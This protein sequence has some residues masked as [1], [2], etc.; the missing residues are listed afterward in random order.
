MSEAAQ[1]KYSKKQVN[2]AGEIL[3]NPNSFGDGEQ[4]WANFVMASWRRAEAAATS[5]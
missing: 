1:R 2:H 3:A 4:L 5:A